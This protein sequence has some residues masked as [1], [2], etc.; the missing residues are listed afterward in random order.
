MCFRRYSPGTQPIFFKKEE[1][2]YKQVLA[3]QALRNGF[4]DSKRDK[5]ACVKI[6]GK[7]IG[8]DTDL[9]DL[10]CEIDIQNLPILISVSATTIIKEKNKK[11]NL[12]KWRES[13]KRILKKKV[14][15]E[16]KL[17]TPKTVRFG[18][19]RDI[20]DEGDNIKIVNHMPALNGKTKSPEVMLERKNNTVI[21]NIAIEKEPSKKRWKLLNDLKNQKN[22]A[23]RK[24]VEQILDLIVSLVTVKNI[25]AL[26][27]TIQQKIFRS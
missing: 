25:L 27:P 4:P 12:S 24:I 20:K 7:N 17:V 11:A 16:A 19:F 21:I 22:E 9:L 8:E 15:K 23:A 18:I 10:K 26:F 1:S 3:V 14:E 2:Q 13:Q 6:I 5:I